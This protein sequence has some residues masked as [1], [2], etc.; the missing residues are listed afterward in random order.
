[1]TYKHYQ[2]HMA[3]G[4]RAWWIK[5]GNNSKE[6]RSYKLLSEAT[7]REAL[8]NDGFCN[9]LDTTPPTDAEATKRWKVK[10]GKTMYALIVNIEDE[11]LQRIKSA[12]TPKE[13]W[14]TLETIFTKKND[15]KL[16]RLE[17]LSI[18]QQNVMISQYFSKNAITDTMMRRII[19]HDLRPEY[20][21]TITA[22][23]GWAI[24][25][26]LSELENLL[27]NE[28]DW[29]RHY[30]GE[31]KRI[32][33]K[34]LSDKT[35]RRKALTT[36]KWRSATIVERKGTTPDTTSTRKLKKD[37]EEIWDFETYYAFEETNQQEEL[38]IALTTISE[39]LVDYEHDW[40]VNS[41]CSNHMT[42][43]EKNLINISEYKGGQVVVTANN[44]KMPITHIGKTVIVP[45]HNSRQVEL[46][47]VYHVPFPKVDD[48]HSLVIIA[49][50]LSELFKGVKCA[51]LRHKK[52]WQCI[53]NGRYWR[54]IIPCHQ[55]CSKK[56]D[57][58]NFYGG[59]T[60]G[61][62]GEPSLPEILRMSTMAFEWDI[63]EADRT[64]HLVNFLV[65][66]IDG[67]D[68]RLKGLSMARPVEPPFMDWSF[69]FLNLP[70][71]PHVQL[72]V[73]PTAR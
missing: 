65:D 6:R 24:K 42:G 41:G 25:S 8:I 56:A 32:N 13:A 47:N 43:D 55:M 54:T 14:D 23:R 12:K 28:E 66:A 31:T 36:G 7:N 4:I 37:E 62:S 63:G 73:A 48:Y 21:G 51:G 29:R 70:T 15:A 3:Y 27:A 19:V 16:Q 2:S 58:L 49:S 22:T 69:L 61:T 39:K 46:P 64:S 10:V 11:F 45:H 60:H 68:L 34:E 71:I 38:E 5:K 59:G 72:L 30:P 9:G 44:S 50:D 20:K 40:I 18:S 52:I 26:T 17:L 1:M 57:S 35:R 67:H 53:P 33:I